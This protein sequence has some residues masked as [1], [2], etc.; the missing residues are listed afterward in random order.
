MIFQMSLAAAF[1]A[2]HFPPGPLS[3]PVVAPQSL[4]GLPNTSIQYY[5][6]SGSTLTAINAGIATHAP[7]DPVTGASSTSSAQWTVG[8]TVEEETLDG[9]CVVTAARSRFSASVVLP[10]LVSEAT[11]SNDLRRVW[12][13]YV[14]NLESLHAAELWFVVQRLGQLERA[15]IGRRCDEANRL[16]TASAGIIQKELA[17][18]SRSNRKAPP[19]VK[20][21]VRDPH[22]PR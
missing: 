12:G 13:Q 16:A 21:P 18:F 22:D 15:V 4:H 14:S 11:A 3:P 1:V 2:A 7:R 17:E 10:R 19:S 20:V 9:K 8:I 5:Y 6:V